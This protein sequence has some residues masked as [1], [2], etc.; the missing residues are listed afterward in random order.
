[1]KQA[2]LF[3]AYVGGSAL[4][5]C[6]GPRAVRVSVATTTSATV[7][8]STLAALPAPLPSASAEEPLPP[9]PR[10]AERIVAR[11]RPKLRACYERGLFEDPTMSGSAEVHAL[12]AADGSVMRVD[13]T[14]RVGLSLVVAGCLAKQVASTSFEPPGR[15]AALDVPVHFVRASS[16]A[17]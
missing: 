16:S 8:A 10:N 14:K 15:T 5:A 7:P 13:V 12:I 6:A 1:M 3:V 17:R 4:V 2:R 9:P 11:L